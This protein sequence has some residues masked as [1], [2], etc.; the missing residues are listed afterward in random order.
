MADGEPK[1]AQLVLVE[2]A[3]E[4]RL[5]LDRVGRTFEQA[6]LAAL[7]DL[8]VM[9]ADDFVE[10]RLDLLEEQSEFDALVAPDVG[11]GR[12]SGAKFLHRGRDDAFLVFV[13]E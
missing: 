5:V 9:A 7:L 13:L 10:T 12:A 3:E 11:T 6:K 1:P 4:I 8:R 2:R